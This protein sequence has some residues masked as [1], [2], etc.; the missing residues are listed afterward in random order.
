MGLMADANAAL[1]LTGGFAFATLVGGFFSKGDEY[2]SEGARESLAN[3]MKGL[4]IDQSRL[5][6]PKMFAGIFDKVFGPDPIKP[7]FMLRSVL[8]SFIAVIVFL[9]IYVSRTPGFAESLFE[10]PEQ[11]WAVARQLVSYSLGI[12]LLVDWLSLAYCQSVVEQMKR[13]SSLASIPSYILKEVGMKLF[14]FCLLTT[15]LYVG[16]AR[17]G[18]FGGR[19]DLALTAV[20]ETLWGGLRFHNITCVYIYSSLLSSFWLWGGAISVVLYRILSKVPAFVNFMKRT[21]PLDKP[22]RSIGVI[23]AMVALIGY[24]VAMALF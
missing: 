2:I 20:P 19:I 13:S 23:S 12:N 11:R 15:F 24:Y 5:S 3:W 18:S 8:V 14:M 7:S 17:G 1:T 22:I 6:F 10:D 9:L 21:L 16:A 4:H